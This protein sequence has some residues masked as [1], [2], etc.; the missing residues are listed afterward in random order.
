MQRNRRP[1]RETHKLCAKRL[2]TAKNV[3]KTVPIQNFGLSTSTDP[4][5]IGV[6]LRRS[7]RLSEKND[8]IFN[9]VLDKYENKKMV[10][11][12]SRDIVVCNRD[13]IGDVYL[14]IYRAA[15]LVDLRSTGK[16]YETGLGISEQQ[17]FDFQ[18]EA[19]E[20][21]HQ[22]VPP[23]EWKFSTPEQQK[24]K[25]QK[26]KQAQIVPAVLHTAS[27][28]KMLYELEQD[29]FDTHIQLNN[30]TTEQLFEFDASCVRDVRQFEVNEQQQHQNER[31][32]MQF[33]PIG[34]TV[35]EFYKQV[36]TFQIS[37]KRQWLYSPSV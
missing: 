37:F 31:A 35:G 22:P 13:V 11:L 27:K 18:T 17:Q 25:P 28:Y 24:I 34:E 3:L 5:S 19:Q 33:L 10:E 8:D 1:R 29:H 16:C 30:V 15:A 2:K 36:N 7:K 4:E 14:E 21:P 32:I 12:L 6:A 26:P 23:H 20:L 9:V